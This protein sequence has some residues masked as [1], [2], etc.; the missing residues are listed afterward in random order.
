MVIAYLF[1]TPIYFF[2][3]ISFHI[4]MIIETVP[5]RLR[6]PIPGQKS[7][8]LEKKA[9]VPLFPMRASAVSARRPLCHCVSLRKHKKGDLVRFLPAFFAFGPCFLARATRKR[10]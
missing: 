10:S 1:E 3:I 5:Y 9:M 7:I 2:K 8:R 4:V 6:G